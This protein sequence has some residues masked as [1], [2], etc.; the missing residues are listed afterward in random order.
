MCGEAPGYIVHHIIPL[1]PAN[2]NDAEVALNHSNMRYECKDCHDREEV[3]CFVGSRRK[4]KKT[5]CA[6]DENG[7]PIPP[8]EKN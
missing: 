3:H 8:V 5:L 4:S 6:F 2:V 1:T 7:Q